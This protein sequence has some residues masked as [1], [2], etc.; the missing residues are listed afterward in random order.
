MRA[1]R[2]ALRACAR[3]SARVPDAPRAW[4]IAPTATTTMLMDASGTRAVMTSVRAEIKAMRST[5]TPV[6]LKPEAR[7]MEA[8]MTSFEAGATQE[9]WGKSGGGAAPWT[10]T[11]ELKKRKSYFKRCGHMMETL[12][13]EKMKELA[14]ERHIVPFRPG[15]V[16]KLT[17]E[18]PEN[19]RRTQTFTGVCIAKKHRGLGS[20]FTLRTA[21]GNL[22][23]ERS[24][25]LF[26]PNIKA[27]E[28][29]ER[30]K[31]RRAKLYYLREKP[32][33]FSR[34]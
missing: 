33:R 25:P 27:M 34:P 23:V 5:G 22:A 2:D 4:T 32:L 29:L 12:E 26:T 28:I 7:G 3:S 10:P 1:C 15:D 18:V 24:F 11:R 30:R 9:G 13:R 21:I 19:N 6:K 8:P 16:V 14:A 17:L 20:S 31:V